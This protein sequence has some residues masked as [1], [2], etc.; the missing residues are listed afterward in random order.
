MSTRP[1]KAEAEVRSYEEAATFLGPRDKRRI[2]HNTWVVWHYEDDSFSIRYGRT[3]DLITY[4]NDGTFLVSYQGYWEPA[5]IQR[6]HQFGPPGWKFTIWG[7]DVYGAFHD[8]NVRL[9]SGAAP[10]PVNP[11]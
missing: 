11:D 2:S 6:L 10:F 8:H 1:V 4:H 9:M 7:I 3:A 5:Y